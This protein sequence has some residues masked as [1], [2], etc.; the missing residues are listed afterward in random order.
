MRK[1]LLTIFIFIVLMCSCSNVYDE[2]IISDIK[3]YDTIWTLPERRASET[4]ILF[5]SIIE[6][7]KVI[8]FRCKHTTY[9]LV[10]TGWQV[11]LT[12]KYSDDLFY[13]EVKRLNELCYNSIICGE[14]KYFDMPAYASVWNHIGCFEYAVVNEEDKTI[15]YLYLQLI[16]KDD[17]EISSPYIPQQYEM[18]YTDFEAYT[19][20]S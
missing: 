15:G 7:E 5:P 14:S 12:V 16:D 8:N 10:G 11:E 20:Y 2:T 6:E 4:S 1:V 17:L 13:D 9:Q 18:D 3:L 19:I